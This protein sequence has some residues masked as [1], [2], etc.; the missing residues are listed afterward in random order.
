[1]SAP[2]RGDPCSTAVGVT[3]QVPPPGLLR[4]AL[5]ALLAG[6]TPA[7]QAQGYGGWFSAATAGMLRSVRLDAGTAYVDLDAALA[8][9]IPN[10]ST[11]CGSGGLLAQLDQTVLQFPTVA[12]VRYSFEGDEA[13][14]YEWLQR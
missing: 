10:A 7:E 6:P 4:G 9:T 11:S 14:F 8:T 1:M 2:A 12:H 13:A 3:R 5:E